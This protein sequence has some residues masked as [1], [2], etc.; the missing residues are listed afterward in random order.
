MAKTITIEFGAL[1]DP[2]KKQLQDQGVSEM[3]G[4]DLLQSRA[5]AISQLHIAGLLSDSEARRA[6]NRLMKNLRGSIST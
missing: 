6:R 4:I 3:T 1:C 5:D 2:I